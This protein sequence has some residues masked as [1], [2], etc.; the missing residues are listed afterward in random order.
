MIVEQTVGGL[1]RDTASR[2]PDTVAL[3]AGE[4][5]W[6]Y[7]ELLAQSER[8]A[9][10]LLAR[11]EPGQRVAIWAHNIPEWVILELGAALAGI[12]IVTVN[13][14]LRAQELAH[15]LGQSRADGI[16]LVPSYRGSPMAE[17]LEEVR[18]DLRDVISFADWD[19]FCDAPPGRLPDVDPGGRRARCCIT[20]GSSTTRGW[21]TSGS[22][23]RLG[24][25][26]SARCR[27]STRRGAR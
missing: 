16:F 4:R 25:C 14:A 23:P 20:A 7:A 8:A 10:A 1:L 27:C 9:H 12:T 17:M 5:T 2:V 22:A 11:F 26:S 13:P 3:V 24:S 6:T 21:P 15:V 19:A 18:G